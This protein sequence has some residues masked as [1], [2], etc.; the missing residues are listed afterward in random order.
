MDLTQLAN[1]GEFVGGVAVLVTLIYLAA[2]IRH[3]TKLTQTQIHTELLALG[4]D[5]HNWKRD[6]A[7]ADISVRA[8][9]DYRGLSWPE[10]EQYSTY[11]FQ[12]L[13]VWESARGSYSRGQMSSSFWHAWNSSFHETVK[14][15]GWVAV[16]Q[17]LRPQYAA[18][19]QAHVDSYLDRSS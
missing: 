18:E 3:A 4:H 16:W 8:E 11:V 13:N 9:D 14:Q 15:P 7:F 17:E 6:S 12:L 1:L 10:R 5:A 2:Q 19:F